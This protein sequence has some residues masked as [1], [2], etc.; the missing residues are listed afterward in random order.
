MTLSF[1]CHNFTSPE[2]FN[3]IHIVQCKMLFLAA[4]GHQ[5]RNC[6]TNSTRSLEKK[7][8]FRYSDAVH[9][10][11]SASSFQVSDSRPK[12]V[13]VVSHVGQLRAI[14]GSARIPSW[15]RALGRGRWSWPASRPVL[16]PGSKFVFESD[17][18]VRFRE[19]V[20]SYSSASMLA[21]VVL[22]MAG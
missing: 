14:V 5:H 20:R 8:V 22:S 19:E 10:T 16:S 3:H 1:K 9:V 11:P 18:R 6:Y 2:R 17:G 21:K 12:L 7:D 15:K 13:I 4:A